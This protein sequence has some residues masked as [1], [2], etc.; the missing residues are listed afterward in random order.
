MEQK[1]NNLSFIYD[2]NNENHVVSLSFNIDQRTMF[3]NCSC[4]QEHFCHHIEYVLEYLYNSY[5]HDYEI[6]NIPLKIFENKNKLWLPASETNHD[7]QE[8][9]II[10][11]E[12]LYCQS[13]FHFYC[14]SCGGINTVK[15]CIH[16]DYIIKTLMEH[17]DELKE[18]NDEINNMDLNEM[19]IEC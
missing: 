10:D 1:P 18:Q 17:Y 14:S 3:F 8:N 6:K 19:D 12:I 5:Y 15:S 16:L 9:K 2:L 13:K 7:T 11:M 4:I